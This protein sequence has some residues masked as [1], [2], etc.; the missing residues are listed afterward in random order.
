MIEI[1]YVPS[2]K[3]CYSVDF[4]HSTG[5]IDSMMNILFD[6]PLSNRD[7]FEEI[8][9]DGDFEDLIDET[10][11]RNLLPY[12]HKTEIECSTELPDY[13]RRYEEGCPDSI[14]ITDE[15]FFS[16]E[17]QDFSEESCSLSFSSS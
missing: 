13:I 1:S 17:L 12:Q 15:E 3:V 2:E 10:E 5:Y 11:V 4:K 7:A 6:I 14:N 8:E 9:E 16:E